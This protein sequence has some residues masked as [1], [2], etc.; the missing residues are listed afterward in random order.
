MGSFGCVAA[1]A[2]RR[3]VRGVRPQGGGQVCAILA[4]TGILPN[5]PGS[6]NR[7]LADAGLWRPGADGEPL[8]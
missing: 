7:I 6:L 5:R 2:G 4:N 1:G 8:V 3:M